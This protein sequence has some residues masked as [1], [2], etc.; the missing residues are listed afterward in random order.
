MADEVIVATTADEVEAE[1]IAGR[2]RAEGVQVRIR[3]ES[4]AGIPRQLA[5]S[6]AGYGLGG[7]RIAVP[8]AEADAAR[9]LLSDVEPASPRRH[10]LF[11]V[12]AILVLISFVL[13]WIPGLV[14]LL[15]ALFGIR[16]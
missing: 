16:Y 9:A 1:V 4:Q 15:Q 5:A 14:G 10:P 11:R 8:A 6:G 13:A 3:F 12:V 2:L 7:F